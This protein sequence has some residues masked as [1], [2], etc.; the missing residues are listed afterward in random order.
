[1]IWK[2]CGL[3]LLLAWA[4][5]GWGEIVVGEGPR[6]ARPRVPAKTNAPPT[7]I[8]A[9]RSEDSLHLLNGDRLQGKLLGVDGAAGLL[10]W[11]HKAVREPMHFQTAALDKVELFSRKSAVIAQHQQLLQLVNGDR[12]CGDVVTLDATQ[13]VF[14]TWYAGKLTIAR[15]RLSELSPAAGTSDVFYE[16]PTADLAGWDLDENEQG[17]RPAFRRGALLLPAGRSL[18]RKLPKLPDKVRLEL[19]L[20][21]WQSAGLM[22][23]FFCKET[24]SPEGEAYGLNLM[25]NRVELMRNTTDGDTVSLGAVDVEEQAAMRQRLRMTLLVERKERRFLLLLNGRLMR[26]FKDQHDLKVSG[27]SFIMQAMGDSALRLTKFKVSHWDGR[28]PRLDAAEA[29]SA[30]DTVVLSNGDTL[31]GEVR[32]IAQGTVRLTTAFGTL[33]IP[34]DRIG[35]LRFAGPPPSHPQKGTRCFFGERDALTVQIEKLAD[36]SITGSA[37]G[38]GALKLPLGVFTALEFNPGVKREMADDDEL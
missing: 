27:D 23:C 20:T 36:D 5:R 13:L 11:Q 9:A 32:A 21:G 16:G 29:D 6:P 31:A 15:A 18:G 1:L 17:P 25:G 28:V 19:E 35:R 12:L 4:P 8:V 14:R 34:L 2:F 10:T 38:I 22:L 7:V 33:E 37:E 26:E 3:L 30:R 24:M